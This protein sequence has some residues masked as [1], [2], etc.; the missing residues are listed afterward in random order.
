MNEGGRALV[1]AE[2]VTPLRRIPQGVVAWT[3][4]TIDFVGAET[5]PDLLAGRDVR[6][7]TGHIVAP[8]FVDIHVH[9]GDG[10]D[11]MDGSLEAFAT[12]CAAHARGGTASLL[13]TTVATSVETTI[14]TLQLVEE[15]IGTRLPGAQVLGA[16]VEG[17]WFAAARKGAHDEVWAPRQEELEVLLAWS[18]VIKRLTLAPELPGALEA[19]RA[20]S[21]A[22]IVPCAGHTDAIYQEMMDAIEAGLSH[23]THLWNQTSIVTKVGPYRRGGCTETALLEDDLTVELIAD[24]HHVPA[25]LMRLALKCKGVAKVCVV[26]DAMRGAG[27][28]EGTQWPVG[29]QDSRVIGIIR[30][31]VAVLPDN[32]AFASSVSTMD[33]MVRNA[34][35]LIRLSLPDAVRVATLTPAQIIGVA[36]RKG[37]LAPGR[38]ADIVILDQD[39]GVVETIA[40]GETVFSRGN[41][42]G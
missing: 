17:P 11:F 35:D 23:V 36:D 1:G 2:I 4:T 8:G 27:K 18:R 6:D 14:K 10:A 38:D 42:L 15:A 31:G 12:A 20:L 33:R 28:P 7:L 19:I 34:R 3:G 29:P 39:L 16:H 13:P 26:S 41:G 32:S 22:G 30:D 24:G 40:L 5:P 21:R 37:S 9:G 25:E